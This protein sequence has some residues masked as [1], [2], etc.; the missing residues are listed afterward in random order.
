AFATRVVTGT[1][2][3]PL[4]DPPARCTKKVIRLDIPARITSGI[5]SRINGGTRERSLAVNLLSGQKSSSTKTK[6][7]VTSI[8]FAIRPN[9]NDPATTE[10]VLK[11]G[12]RAYFA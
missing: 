2:S 3:A 12:C 8:G 9:T 4:T 5:F 1:I 7:S 11:P 6:G 10:Y